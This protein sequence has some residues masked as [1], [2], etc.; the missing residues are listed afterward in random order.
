M[1]MMWTVPPN[2][3]T[4]DEIQRLALTRGVGL[5]PLSKAAAHEYGKA[6]LRDR[7][8]VLGY[9]ALSEGEIRD[10]IARVAAAIKG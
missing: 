10:A 5:Y 4:A 8:L 2:L 1:H 6:H 7:S 9:T 3:P